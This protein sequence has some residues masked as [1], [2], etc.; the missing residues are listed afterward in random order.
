M[1]SIFSKKKKL[2]L[3]G[4]SYIYLWVSVFIMQLKIML[5]WYYFNSFFPF[6]LRQGL[7]GYSGTCYAD[8]AALYLTDIC[9]LLPPKCLG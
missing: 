3:K 4:E 2:L 5:V 1:V 6:L 7:C 8:Q 9:L